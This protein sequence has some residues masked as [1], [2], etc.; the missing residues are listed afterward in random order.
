MKWG[1]IRVAWVSVLL[2]LSIGAPA[3]AE[4]DQAGLRTEAEKFWEARVK[5]DWLV[6]YDYLP[7][8]EMQQGSREEFAVWSKD[9]QPFQYVSY[10][11]GTVET[12]ANFGWVQVGY[13]AKLPKYPSLPA[14]EMEIWQVWRKVGDGWKLVPQQQAND[15]PVPIHRRNAAEEAVLAKRAEAYWQAR[16]EQ[17][18]GRL[19]GYCDPAFRGRVSREEFLQKKARYLY[20]SHRI[21]WTEVVGDQGRV[22]VSYSYKPNDPSLSKLE[23]EQESTMEAWVK[24]DGEWYRHITESKE[25]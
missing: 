10:K 15:F 14:R 1:S 18:L 5:G 24:V 16:A 21:D 22:R 2:A 19:Y 3:V 23:A 25:Q 8:A 17:D 4:N 9:N 11:L 7:A 12:D 20:L 13:S 6:L